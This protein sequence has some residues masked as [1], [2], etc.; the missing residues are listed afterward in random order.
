VP[1]PEVAWVLYK[2]DAPIVVDRLNVILHSNGP[3][4]VEGFVGNSPDSL[5]SIGSVFGPLGDVTGFG[6]PCFD[7]VLR[8]G[9][10][11]YEGQP[12][13]FDFDDTGVAGTYFKFVVRK[14]SLADGFALYRGG[15][16]FPLDTVVLPTLPTPEP[17]TTMVSATALGLLL[18]L[19]RKVVP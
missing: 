17:A 15:P 10:A 11:F 14:S 19:R 18:V 3:T 12:Y 13:S 2:Y 1:D 16:D 6:E 4:Q 8:P 9:C 7:G 5:T